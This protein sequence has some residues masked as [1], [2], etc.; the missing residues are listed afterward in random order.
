V[1]AA[2]GFADP[3]DPEL[4]RAGERLL[5]AAGAVTHAI[6]GRAPDHPEGP[7]AS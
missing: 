1:V 6:N 2:F 7:R 5:G 4:T 3:V